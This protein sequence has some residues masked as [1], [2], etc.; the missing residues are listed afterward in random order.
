M[1]K[2]FLVVILGALISGTYYSYKYSHLSSN[3][4][5]QQNI[6]NQ[7]DILK[8]N[9]QTQQSGLD[10]QAN[11]DKLTPGKDINTI[12]QVITS[13]KLKL[14]TAS[15]SSSSTI[16]HIQPKTP[17]NMLEAGIHTQL[18]VLQSIKKG[19]EYTILLNKRQLDVHA[20]SR[21]NLVKAF[22]VK[23]FPVSAQVLLLSYNQG[24]NQCNIQY[25]ILQ[26]N[27][28]TY[29][30]TPVFGSCLNLQTISQAS[31]KLIIQMPQN[32]PYLGD[33][34]LITYKYYN[35]KIHI[36]SPS[37]P[38]QLRQKY[39]K[40]D[41]QQILQNAIN[42]KCYVNGVFLFDNACNNG[43]KYCTM[44]KHLTNH[45]KNHAYKIL[46]DFCN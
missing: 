8:N 28:K 12:D 44:F 36:A 5:N 18:G 33:D 29:N 7:S 26:L 41:A 19:T 17:T 38:Q 14:N 3:L 24:G 20:V 45:T 35:D 11:S 30:L 42:D 4:N 37:T 2:L 39:A 32:N 1:K 13:D 22:L 10:G 21:I 9:N 27:K 23:K 16:A 6:T 40:L 15:S 43:Q 31:N 34:V 46:Q 25:Q